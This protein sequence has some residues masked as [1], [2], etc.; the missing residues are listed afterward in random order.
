MQVYNI[1]FQIAPTLQLQ[2]LE[3][4]KSKFIPTI[5]ATACFSDH[6]FY[7]ID[8]TEDQAPTYTLQL[9]TQNPETLIQYQ[10]QLS[11]SIMDD[12]HNTWGDQCFHFITTM[13]IVN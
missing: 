12:L 10:E 6:Q 2:W 11:P 8:I 9:Y 13:R 3:W 5:Q 7:E 1:S 4:M